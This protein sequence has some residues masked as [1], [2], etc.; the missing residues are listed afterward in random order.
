ML[1]PILNQ[2]KAKYCA[3]E[4]DGALGLRMLWIILWCYVRMRHMPNLPEYRS[5]G[6]TP[7]KSNAAGQPNAYTVGV[8]VN[9]SMIHDL[10]QTL[11]ISWVITHKT[12]K[13]RTLPFPQYFWL[14]H[15]PKELRRSASTVKGLLVSFETMNDVLEENEQQDEN[16]NDP[17]EFAIKYAR[18]CGKLKTTR[19]T[20]W[21]V[22]IQQPMMFLSCYIL[23]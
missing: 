20:G 13:R 23:E 9:K 12:S 18:I 4:K 6:K 19:R 3:M 11:L 21:Y 1:K 8:P 16:D 10:L 17:I 2:E 5:F 22:A 14:L 7:E 15:T